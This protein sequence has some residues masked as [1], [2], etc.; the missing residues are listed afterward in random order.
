MAIP[1]VP[2]P[3]DSTRRLAEKP[4][5]VPRSTTPIDLYLDG[6]EGVGV[7]D[8]VISALARVTP[9]VLR[10]YPS[11]ER[12][13][14]KL[15]ERIGVEAECVLVTA[16][17]D[18][19]ID[20]VF[21]VFLEPGCR[22]I[23]HRPSFEMIQRFGR[24]SGASID[25]VD[26][27]HG[28]LPIDAFRA[29]VTDDTSA[30]AVVSPNNPT[31]ATVEA[32]AL[33]ALAALVPDGVLLV[34]LAYIEF[35][36]ED[37]TPVVLDLPNAVAIRTLSKAYGLAGA[38]VGYMVGPREIV[39]MVRANSAPYGVAA[40]SLLLAEQRLDNEDDVA[41]YVRRVQSERIQL[42]QLLRKLRATPLPSEGNFL[43]ARFKNAQWVQQGLAGLGIGVRSFPGSDEAKDALRITC[44][45]QPQ[46]FGRLC[47]AL[48]TVM[49][50]EAVLFDLDGVI[51]NVSDSYRRCIISTAETYGVTV[52]RE[53]IAQAKTRLGSN[54]D[55]ILTYDFVERA[56]V[57]TTLDEVTRRFQRFYADYRRNE[58]LCV[59][60]DLLETVAA[61]VP[62]AVV[63]GRPREDAER[64]LSEHE[65]TELFSVVVC[66][67][68]A[69][70]KPDPA[71]VRLAL[72]QLRVER[73]W[74]FGDT[75]DDMAAARG[76]GVVPIG[77]V[78]PGD[79]YDC[80]AENLLAAGG[81]VVLRR[82][83]DLMEATS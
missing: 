34:D 22:L 64:F 39:D 19:A 6:N 80:V 51:A 30:I 70:P 58:R 32:E 11:R 15:A 26:W 37:L 23:T 21:R 9:E 41:S 81:A 10:G 46:A 65:L 48:Q 14:R 53:Q 18:D 47:K 33:R 2:E 75:A 1:T 17:G 83:D 63:T 68:D 54:N 50:P 78:A 56:G 55:W 61:R 5:S 38:R 62:L 44:P 45:G 25:V 60:R 28:D 59:D 13:E 57:Q 52:T 31:G 12:V 36:S 77:V 8:A 73:A 71:P 29:A 66:M 20:R 69:P 43:F 49:D 82:T 42:H 72:Q 16:G 27:L 7:P 40:P 35:A 4:Y 3:F 24:L 79:D 76:A 74:M 67:E